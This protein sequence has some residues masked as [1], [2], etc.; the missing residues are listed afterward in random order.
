M[1]QQEFDD[2][3][4]LIQFDLEDL[5]TIH[6]EN[7]KSILIVNKN[8]ENSGAFFRCPS[9]VTSIHTK[10]FLGLK[11]ILPSIVQ[12]KK[13]LNKINSVIVGILPK[14]LS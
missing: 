9:N 7:N 10:M 5:L 3:N 2:L 6:D 13:E 8:N 11:A 14:K 4:G 1:N 12:N